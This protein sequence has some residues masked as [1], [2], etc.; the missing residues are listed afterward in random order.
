MASSHTSLSRLLTPLLSTFRS[1]IQ[2]LKPTTTSAIMPCRT[3]SSTP[4]PL[5]A[6]G[7]PPSRRPG[8]K[9]KGPPKDARIKLI[10]Y[11]M[12]HPK[13]PRPL[14][15]SRMRALRHWT[16]HR[17]WMLA[18]R[19]RVEGEESELMRMYQSMHAA[20]EELRLLDPPGTK[21]AGRLYRIAMEKKGIFGHGG[22][23]IE[24]AR[25]Q[26]ETPPREAWNHAWTR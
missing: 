15:L 3:F 21:D 13:T 5:A 22:V 8:G 4:T 19:K 7:G 23:P 25:A 26:T 1:S 11:H 16:I 2:T 14:K 20:C 24:Y 18:Q 12:Q 10:R 17:A 6:G 9:G